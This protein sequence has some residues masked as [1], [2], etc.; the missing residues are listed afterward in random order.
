MRDPAVES[1]LGKATPTTITI[2][3]KEDEYSQSV[4]NLTVKVDGKHIP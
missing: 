4:E 3:R 1:K 2:E